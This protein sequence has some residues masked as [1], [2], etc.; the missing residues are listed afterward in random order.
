MTAALYRRIE[1]S[2]KFAADVAHE[3]K[4]PLTAARSTAELLSYAQTEE[5]RNQ[6]V[7]TIQ[8]ELKRLNKL[9]TDVSNAS[10]LDAELA[11]QRVR[12]VRRRPACLTGVTDAFRDIV[13]DDGR[14]VVLDIEPSKAGLSRS[15]A[16]RA[17][18]G[19]WRRT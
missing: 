17:G 14:K 9:I 3:L 19:R 4:N 18:S 16:S 7:P 11:L 10:R 12:A 2:E 6:L 8:M 5:Q 1:A 15:R 13:S